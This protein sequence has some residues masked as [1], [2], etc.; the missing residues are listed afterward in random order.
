MISN[1][2]LKNFKCFEDSADFSFARLNVLTG[3]NGRG[4][5]TVLQSMILLAQ[6]F[7]LNKSVDTLVLNGPYIDIGNYADIKSS[8]SPRSEHIEIKVGFQYEKHTYTYVF[9]YSE[10]EGDPF[11]ADLQDLVLL[12][13]VDASTREVLFEAFCSYLSRFHYVSADR[14]GPVKYVEKGSLGEKIDTGARGEHSLQILAKSMNLETV[15]KALYRGK[16][17][18]SVLEQ[19]TEWLRYIFG[20]AK[21]TIKGQENESSI[22]YLLLNSRS[23]SYE[24]KPS[25]V[26]FGYSYILPLIVSGLISKPG[27]TIIVE[28]P[29]AHL[30]PQAQSRMIE[31]FARV[32]S[33]GVQVFIE[34]HSEH[35]LN[36]ARVN[37]VASQVKIMPTNCTFH[38]FN[39]D[40]AYEAVELGEDGK[41]DKWPSGFF[42]QQDKDIAE[43]FRINRI[44][45]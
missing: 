38:F 14:L 39:E 12:E 17:S 11:R 1:L 45:K 8:T 21:V 35:I 22:L 31:F 16:D 19:T 5:S 4:K 13:D 27:D 43:L 34:T 26:G 24:Y 29:E 9:T 18:A 3:M 30:H 6:S 2:Q 7:V 28:N 37:A 25:N 33:T 40:Y 10:N 41:M 23:N 36:G 32:A 20:G 44:K 42:D 15:N